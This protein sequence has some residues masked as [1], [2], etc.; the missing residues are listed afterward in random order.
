[1]NS[2]EETD[3]EQSAQCKPSIASLLALLRPDFVKYRFRLLFGFFA[4]LGVDFLQLTIPL[5][6]KQAVDLLQGG[7]ATS[8]AL[9]HLGALLL[10]TAGLIL[11]LRCVSG[12]FCLDNALCIK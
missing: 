7:T 8:Q 6:M 9:C 5:Y 12:G 11:A 4:L 3:P 10:L 1:M 2:Q